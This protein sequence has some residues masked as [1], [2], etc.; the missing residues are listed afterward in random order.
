MCPRQREEIEDGYLDLDKER[1]GVR[2]K[3][4]R[5]EKKEVEERRG[6]TKRKIRRTKNRKKTEKLELEKSD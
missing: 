1:H 5:N 6:F 4:N 2:D 3:E